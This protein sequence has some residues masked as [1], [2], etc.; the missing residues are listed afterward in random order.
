MMT[1]C[2]VCVC[3]SVHECVYAYARVCVYISVCMH[4]RVCVHMCVQEGVWVCL[5]EGVR[6]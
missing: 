2:V 4:K 6:P 3:M 5:C 1:P